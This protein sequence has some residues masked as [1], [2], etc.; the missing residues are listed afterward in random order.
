MKNITDKFRFFQKAGYFLSN[1]KEFFSKDVK[2]VPVVDEDMKKTLNEMKEISQ[3]KDAQ[4][5]MQAEKL[6]SQ[7]ETLEKVQK[8]CEENLAKATVNEE[9]LIRL[10]EKV[11]K[12]NETLLYL[13]KI[14]IVVSVVSVILNICLC[15]YVV[16]NINSRKDSPL[17]EFIENMEII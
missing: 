13:L 16:I 10:D 8:L 11:D 7:T 1:F 17:Q 15:A 2:I 6:Q 3:E 12:N 9:L 4:S 5:A 14:A